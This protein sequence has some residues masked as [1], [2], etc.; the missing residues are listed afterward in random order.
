MEVF[1]ANLPKAVDFTTLKFRTAGRL[2]VTTIYELRKVSRSAPKI[3]AMP[4][5]GKW[6]LSLEEIAR[7][8]LI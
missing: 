2:R 1:T 8:E 7:S 6:Q 3:G 4:T 5:Y